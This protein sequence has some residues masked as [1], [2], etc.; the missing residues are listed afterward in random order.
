MVAVGQKLDLG[1]SIVLKGDHDSPGD[2]AGTVDRAG[3]P[4]AQ[5]TGHA[6][7]VVLPAAPDHGIPLAHQEAIARVQWI[8]RKHVRSAVE[9]P[10][11]CG[12]APVQDVQQHS[13]VAPLR[14]NRLHNPE[15][16]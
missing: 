16:R 9:I 13:S 2:R 5:D 12:F 8:G 6:G 10:Q 4:H 7:S 14:V 3:R 15:I 11:R 1:W